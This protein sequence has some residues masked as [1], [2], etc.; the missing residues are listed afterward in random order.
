M[1]KGIIYC[2]VST[3]RQNNERQLPI[4][5]EYASNN[6]IQIIKIFEEKISGAINTDERVE[7]AALMEYIDNN[8]VEIILVNE[9]SRIG[10]SALDVLSFIKKYKERKIPIYFADKTIL[11]LN[12]DGTNND[13]ADFITGILS[14]ISEHERQ[15]IKFRTSE[16]KFFA[17]VNQHKWSNG[18]PPFGYTK[19]EDDKLIP[20]PENSKIVKKIYEMYA[21]GIST[22]KIANYLNSIGQ[23]TRY[24]KGQ[25]WEGTVREIIISEF[26]KGVRLYQGKYK[27][28]TPA[29]VDDELWQ[30]AN[31]R[32][33][34]MKGQKHKRKY[35]YKIP[36]YK[37][38]CGV[39]GGNMVYVN[40]E[41]TRGINCN[42]HRY[43]NRCKNFGIGIS[44]LY[45]AIYATV[46]DL[47]TMLTKRDLE[48]ERE[49]ILNKIQT[50]ETEK[51]IIKNKIA[52]EEDRLN[53]VKS[54]Y[55]NLRYTEE[56]FNRK[57]DEIKQTTII[58]EEL[59]KEI[60]LNLSKLKAIK[61]SD[62][63]EFDPNDKDRINGSINDLIEKITIYPI[64]N[65]EIHKKLNLSNRKSEYYYFIEVQTHMQKPPMK[66]IIS[67][68]TKRMLNL[69]P[70]KADGFVPVK[71]IYNKDRYTF[72]INQRTTP[73]Y[74]K[75]LN[76]KIIEE[77]DYMDYWDYNS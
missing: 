77:T 72:H 76:S 75:Q 59:L 62:N 68:Y 61:I 60:N 65:D 5:E 71:Y 54:L 17:I 18:V 11:T 63:Y 67:R 1:K 21:G 56:E 38:T 7:M 66:F 29:L 33:N 44:T 2:R 8:D 24:G 13:K 48:V 55:I 27:I 34:L 73:E 15:Q 58:Q 52:T 69:V 46:K 37:F 25:W 74:L 6:N 53:R 19:D 40:R 49:L 4:L 28:P 45:N 31:D 47:T 20:H 16:G 64:L 26:S 32:M 41:N 36:S 43:G 14:V 51:E 50:L 12:L 57:Y 35:S 23:K 9:L 39:C 10:R 70:Y 3:S 30:K 42:T 22:L